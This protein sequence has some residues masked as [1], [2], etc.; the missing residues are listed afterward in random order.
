VATIEKN[1]QIIDQAIAESRAALA[2]DP[3]NPDLPLMLSGVYQ[4]KVELLQHAVQLSSRT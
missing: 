3:N 4:T 2:R 1:L